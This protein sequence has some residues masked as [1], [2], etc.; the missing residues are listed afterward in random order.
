[1]QEQHAV[2]AQAQRAQELTEA[3]YAARCCAWCRHAH[4]PS[5]QVRANGLEKLIKSLQFLAIN[6]TSFG[7]ENSYTYIEITFSNQHQTAVLSF[8]VLIRGV[9]YFMIRSAS[10]CFAWQNCFRTFKFRYFG[11]QSSHH[12]AHVAC[13]GDP[14]GSS[15]F[16]TGL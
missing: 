8:W 9:Q 16:P 5:S 6:F 12:Q 2:S 4:K 11:R 7:T 15:A 3:H 13:A 10:V 1:M 14:D